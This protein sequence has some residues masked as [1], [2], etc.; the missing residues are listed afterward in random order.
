MATICPRL[1]ITVDPERAKIL[2]N[3]AKQNNQSISALAKELI[4]EALELR[5]DLILSTL[6]KKRDSKSQKRISHQDAWK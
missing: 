6:A 2:A 3:L 5:E 4:I 1:S